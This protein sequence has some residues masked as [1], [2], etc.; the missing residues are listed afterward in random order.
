MGHLTAAKAKGELYLVA[1]L[2][3]LEDLLHLGL[4]VVIVDVRTHFDL[5]DLLRLLALAL[6]VGFFLRLVLVAANIEEFGDGRICPRADFN[7]VEADLLSLLESLTR[8]H[9]AQIFAIFV[10]HAHLGRLNELIVA[11]AGHC[12]RGQRAARGGRVMGGGAG[13]RRGVGCGIAKSLG[14]F[15][16]ARK[17]GVSPAD[18][19]GER[20]KAS[21][22]RGVLCPNGV[23]RRVQP[24]AALRAASG[25]GP[26][27]HAWR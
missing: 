11:G 15:G 26:A 7:Q 25:R 21:Y 18:E 5:F 22:F 27:P 23:S 9:Y 12:W 3:E 6:L 8:I 17:L 2:E 20:R 1:F 4:I 13:G 10:D 19:K 24:G 14:V 16:S